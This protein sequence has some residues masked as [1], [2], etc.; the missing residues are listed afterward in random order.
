MRSSLFVAALTLCAPPLAL[1]TD[2]TWLGGE[3]DD[4]YWAENWDTNGIPYENPDGLVSGADNTIIITNGLNMPTFGVPDFAAKHV[5]GIDDA[6]PNF[7]IEAGA[8]LAISQA[9]DSLEGPTWGNGPGS[10]VTVGVGASLTLSTNRVDNNFT[11]MRHPGGTQTYDINGGTLT[12]DVNRLDWGFNNERLGNFDVD[13]GSL[14]FTGSAMFGTR[15]GSGTY[16]T[17]SIVT[18]KNSSTFSALNAQFNGNMTK[19]DGVSPTLVFDIQDAGSSLTAKFGSVFPDIDAVVAGEGVYWT[20]STLGA[21]SLVSTDNLDGTFTVNVE[22]GPPPVLG[23][24]MIEVNA[25]GDVILTWAG[26]GVLQSDD[27]LEDPW[28]DVDDGAATSPYTVPAP[29]DSREFYR[30]RP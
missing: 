14:V 28:A 23:P 4:W 10:F 11:V 19:D 8:S 24:L 7:V 25:S 18:L 1:A 5:S 20:S 2:Y 29:T 30:L 26:G 3:D 12:F 9:E 6:S 22:G 15:H 27:D 16:T 13:G 21:A 17:P